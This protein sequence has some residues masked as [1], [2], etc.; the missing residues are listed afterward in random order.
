MNEVSASFERFRTT[1]EIPVLRR[2]QGSRFMKGDFHVR[3]R[4][5]P[6]SDTRS[7]S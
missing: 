1:H 2:T 7:N 6:E 4:E 5:Y 3:V